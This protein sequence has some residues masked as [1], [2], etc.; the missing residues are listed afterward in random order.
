MQAA[1][2]IQKAVH[3]CVI[4]NEAATIEA[5]QPLLRVCAER[6]H[7]M[8]A[9]RTKPG[10]CDVVSGIVCS[11]CSADV[12]P[13]AAV[14]ESFATVARQHGT[15]AP[16]QVALIALALASCAGTADH[17]C[18]SEHVSSLMQQF[19]NAMRQPCMDSPLVAKAAD[20][21]VTACT[22]SAPCKCKQVMLHGLA[23]FV[24][25]APARQP[26]DDTALYTAVQLQVLPPEH[27]PDF[28]GHQRRVHACLVVANHGSRRHTV[29]FRQSSSIRKLSQQQNTVYIELS[30]EFK[31]MAK[32]RE[33]AVCAFPAEGKYKAL[34][35]QL[36]GMRPLAWEGRLQSE[37]FGGYSRKR[38]DIE[39]K[40]RCAY[41]SGADA[42]AMAGE[43]EGHM[44]LQLCNCMRTPPRTNVMPLPKLMVVLIAD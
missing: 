2:F 44:Q 33:V 11:I 23:S 13:D 15:S 38:E 34:A 43:H 21:I 26:L 28:Q 3:F 27:D 9:V 14:P 30:E 18:G 29:L 35:D 7:T 16:A 41:C 37:V 39:K 36:A 31:V 10:F 42:A 5:L 32:L 22:E 17:S 24:H 12:A 19:D 8:F 1:A 40:P 25:P 20:I 4:Q 6:L